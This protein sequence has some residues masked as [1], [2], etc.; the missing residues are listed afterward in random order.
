[1]PKKKDKSEAE[2][3]KSTIREL[4]KENKQLKKTLSYYE[5]RKHI[6]NDVLQDYEEM[7]VQHVPIEEVKNSKIN[8]CEDCF[9]G[10]I[11]EF[12]I[13]GKVIGTCNNCGFRK[14]IK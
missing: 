8:H 11:E 1:M 7:L 9:K 3:Y 14:R 12:E 6:Y 5:K 10:T 13:M 2:F 4:E